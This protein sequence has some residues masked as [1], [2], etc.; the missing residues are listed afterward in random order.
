MDGYEVGEDY[1]SAYAISGISCEAW[2]IRIIGR[3]GCPYRENSN[4]DSAV[5][6][7]SISTCDGK[8]VGENLNTE[9]TVICCGKTGQYDNIFIPERKTN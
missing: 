5:N 9:G 3:L 4:C 7:C 1:I 6:K 8:I 2:K